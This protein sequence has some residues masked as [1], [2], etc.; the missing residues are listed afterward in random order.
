[1]LESG[2]FGFHLNDKPMKPKEAFEKALTLC[3]TPRSSDI[4]RN[5]AQNASYS[6]CTDAAFQ[7]LRTLICKWFK[8]E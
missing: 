7:K 8:T 4:Y 2:G 1:M 3:K 5:I 6:K